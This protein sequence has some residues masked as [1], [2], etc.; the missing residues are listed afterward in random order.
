MIGVI[1]AIFLTYD[2]LTGDTSIAGLDEFLV[3]FGLFLIV[4]F[5]FNNI[6]T[7][8]KTGVVSRYQERRDR[9]TR[10]VHAH[11]AF[12]PVWMVAQRRPYPDRYSQQLIPLLVGLDVFLVG[13]LLML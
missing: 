3:F 5:S 12:W 6:R 1:A 9:S 2:L 4:I 10:A 13:G 8:Q 11:P 7:P